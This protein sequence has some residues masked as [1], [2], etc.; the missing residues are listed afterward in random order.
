MGLFCI[1]VDRRFDMYMLISVL[2]FCARMNDC[3]MAQLR[4]CFKSRKIYFVM[5]L[6]GYPITREAAD[7]R[8]LTMRIEE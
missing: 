8:P 2:L 6:G 5:D 3:V 4:G 1:F 7:R